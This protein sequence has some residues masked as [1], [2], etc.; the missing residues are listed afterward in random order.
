MSNTEPKIEIS[1]SDEEL[2]SRLERFGGSVVA[3]RLLALENID[4]GI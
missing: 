4:L 2:K 1:A 3:K